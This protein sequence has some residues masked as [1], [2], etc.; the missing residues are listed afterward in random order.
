MLKKYGWLF[1]LRMA[2]SGA[3]FTAMGFAAKA[4]FG[5]MNQ[6]ASDSFNSL[7]GMFPANESAMIF[8]D[9]AGNVIDPGSLGID[10]SQFGVTGGSPFGYGGFSL[11]SGMS[12][13]ANIL[14]NFIIG[15]GLVMLIGGALLAW[16]LKKKGQEAL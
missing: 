9:S 10:A 5:S 6:M 12:D 7:G 13:P 16:Y 8:Y 11:E 14:C 4:M 1:G 15:I 3:I 2:I